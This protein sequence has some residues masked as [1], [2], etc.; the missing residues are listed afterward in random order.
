MGAEAGQHGNRLIDAAAIFGE[1]MLASHAAIKAAPTMAEK[2]AIGDSFARELLKNAEG[3]P[4]WFTRLVDQWLTGAE[5]PEVEDLFEV[6]GLSRRQVERLT[7]RFY[8]ASPKLLARKYRALRAASEIMRNGGQASDKVSDAFYD[9]SHLIREIK[10]F[11]G[12]T[13]G[14][15]KKQPSPLASEVAKERRKLAGKVSKLISDT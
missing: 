3:S 2:V 4:I 9:Q 8:G 1:G 7:K 14:K 5:S 12:V 11:T 15:I 13:P 10:E 6:T